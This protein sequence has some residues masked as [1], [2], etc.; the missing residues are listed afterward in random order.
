MNKGAHIV[1]AMIGILF[2]AVWAMVCTDRKYN[3]LV[4]EDGNHRGMVHC[5]RS[6]K[7]AMWDYYIV[8]SD[9]I[10]TRSHING[11]TGICVK[12]SNQYYLDDVVHVDT[13]RKHRQGVYYMIDDSSR[14]V[15]NFNDVH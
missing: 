9:T 3:A 13:L 10:F 15:V 11:C 12:C 4:C 7:I 2:I 1:N 14:I 8:D 6:K 5:D